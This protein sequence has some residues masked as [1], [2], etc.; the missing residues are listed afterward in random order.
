VLDMLSRGSPG[1]EGG[2]VC[3]AVA[4]ANSCGGVSVE[5]GD[6]VMEEDEGD[7]V[8]AAAS[9]ESVAGTQELISRMIADAE[10]ENV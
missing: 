10:A 3:D 6:G 2:D 8:L 7:D 5:D 1:V 9:V 4:G